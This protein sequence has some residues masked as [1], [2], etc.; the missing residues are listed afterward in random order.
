MSGKSREERLVVL[1]EKLDRMWPP[2]TDVHGVWRREF[3]AVIPTEGERYAGQACARCRV[4]GCDR[5]GLLFHVKNMMTHGAPR[6]GQASR[7]L[8]NRGHHSALVALLG[9]EPTPPPY[10]PDLVHRASKKPKAGGG[11]AAG[12]G[13][14]SSEDREEYDSEGG[15]EAGEG[16][17]PSPSKPAKKPHSGARKPP[18]YHPPSASNV[19]AAA[20]SERAAAAAEASGGRE[21]A[22]FKMTPRNE[23]SSNFVGHEDNMIKYR[24]MRIPFHNGRVVLATRCALGTNPARN[25]K[26]LG[27]LKGSRT[28]WEHA[29]ARAKVNRWR[30]PNPTPKRQTQ[31][32]PNPNPPHPN[33]T[34]TRPPPGPESR[35]AQRRRGC[36]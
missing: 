8:G 4:V 2:F 18:A 34:Q 7:V 21:H 14:G 15:G 29:L 11:A 5:E 3:D 16:G 31:P 32:R 17:A 22:T 28:D 13:G 36:T 33:Q 23:N 1:Q 19:G 27:N 25:V 6:G 20:A 26:F 10:P 30:V 24:G 12:A 9:Y 35:R